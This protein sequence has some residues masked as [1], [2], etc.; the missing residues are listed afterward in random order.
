MSFD[1]NKS[2]TSN[3]TKVKVGINGAAGRMG[4]NLVTACVENEILQLTVATE[5]AKHDALGIDA[6]TLVGLE[7]QGV[8]ITGN[9]SDVID[10][11]DVLIDFTNPENTLTSLSICRKNGRGMVIGTT[12]FSDQERTIITEAS[13]EIPIV[14]APNMSVGITLC[15]TLAEIA[16]R[17]FGNEVD[18]EII[19]A[20]HRQKV[21]APSGTALHLG[22]VIADTLGRDLTKHA[23]YGREGKTGERD[24]QTIGFESIRAGDIVGEH[25][26]MF[27]GDGERIEITHR[28]SSRKIFAH[29]ALRAAHWIVEKENGLFDMQDVLGL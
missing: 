11:C 9:L 1:T 27:A 22:K 17:V 12:G 25:T 23:V 29:G 26:A 19:E 16:A 6:G 8:F 24:P 13:R 10:E 14:L 21:D 20:H 5:H 3:N 18:I 15:F 28:A 2:I 7:Q 4:R